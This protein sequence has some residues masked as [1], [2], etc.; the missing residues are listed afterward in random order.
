MVR[1]N[2]HA[3]E[4]VSDRLVDVELVVFAARTQ[5]GGGGTLQ[6]ASIDLQRDRDVVLATVTQDGQALYYY[7]SNEMK[8]NKSMF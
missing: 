8:G 1:Q 6:D 2:D 4:H 3:L 5:Y 7:A